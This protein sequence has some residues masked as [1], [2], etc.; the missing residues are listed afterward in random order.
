M[1]ALERIDGALN[2][3]R[4]KLKKTKRVSGRMARVTERTQ[5]I[6]EIVEQTNTLVLNVNIQ[7]ARADIDGQSFAVVADNVEALAT[8]SRTTFHDVETM[9]KDFRRAWAR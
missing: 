4:Q 5:L 1:R 9:S 7:V 2:A 8:E 3:S 6:D